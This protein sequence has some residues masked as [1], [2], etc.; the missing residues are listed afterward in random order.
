MRRTGGRG[1]LSRYVTVELTGVTLGEVTAALG[2]LD[3]AH[4]VGERMLEGSLECAGEPV[5]LRCP[6]GVAGTVEDFGFRVDEGTVV[7]ICGELDRDR[8]DAQLLPRLRE[9]IA[10]A[11]L[12]AGGV[13]VE[14]DAKVPLRPHK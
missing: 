11:R 8:L 9:T 12:S 1:A 5:A 4:D 14:P 6:D 2:A 7:L 13:A 10:K 3:V